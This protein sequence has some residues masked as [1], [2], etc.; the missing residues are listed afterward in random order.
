MANR[1]FSSPR[2]MTK[3]QV[4]L[5]GTVLLASGGA[6]TSFDI[7]AVKSVT[8]N[9]TGTYDVVLQDKYTKFLRGFIAFMEATTT[10][11]QAKVTAFDAAAG[12]FTFKTISTATPTN[13]SAITTLFLNIILKN[14]SA[15]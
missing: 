15:K 8:Q 10:A 9:G 1:N 11:L 6:V 4:H 14:S 13:V 5:V 3:E 12:T 7:D 2:A